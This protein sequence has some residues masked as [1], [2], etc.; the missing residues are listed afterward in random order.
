M[1]PAGFDYL[2]A[3]SVDEALALLQEHGDDAKLLAGGHSLIPAMKLRLSEPTKLIDIGRLEELNYIKEQD[4]QICIGAGATHRML[5]TSELVQQKAPLLAQ[6]AAVIGD[7]QVRNM[8]TVGGSLAHADPAADYPA[9]ILAAEAEIHVKGPNGARA[10]AADEYFVDL[11]LTSLQPDE[12]LTEIRVPALA[13]N[14]GACYIKFPHPASRFAMVGCAAL[15]TVEGGT[16]T[17][18]RLGITGAANAAFRD[19]GVEDA[20]TGQAA[21]A[22]SIEAA[23]AKAA[24]GAELMSDVFADEEYRG[25]LTKVYAKRVLL[26]AAGVG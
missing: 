22:A 4:G 25:H 18:V 15:V 21:N 6:A 17:Q 23:A 16:C 9:G 3:T 1:I 14:T 2:R 24:D 5:E 20:L 7:P 8:G 19:T 11:F 13:A 26:K 10:I 12:L